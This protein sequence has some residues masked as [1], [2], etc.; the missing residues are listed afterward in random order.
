MATDT[1]RC[2]GH[3]CRLFYLPQSPQDLV[4]FV[5]RAD[6]RVARGEGNGMDA[7]IRT[8]AAMAIHVAAHD[9][10]S[11]DVTVRSG[12]LAHFTP[13]SD[14]KVHWYTCRHLQPNGDCGIYDVRPPMCRDY[15]YQQPCLYTEC[16]SS[17]ARAGTM[18]A[19]LKNRGRWK[20]PPERRVARLLD[21]PQE[22]R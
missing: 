8:I 5:A 14:G 16:Q 11:D 22:W 19:D 12:F 6:E 7:E 17:C 20:V 4:D 15:P 9:P 13:A 1:D 2:V 10:A 21:A 18:G 3:C